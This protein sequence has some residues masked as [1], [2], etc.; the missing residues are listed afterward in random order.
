[1]VKIGQPKLGYI[2]H[3]AIYYDNFTTGD[4]HDMFMIMLCE[5]AGG[6]LGIIMLWKIRTFMMPWI[7]MLI[8]EYKVNHLIS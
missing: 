7:K 2:V 3:F 1:M 6:W 8:T 4:K 5:L